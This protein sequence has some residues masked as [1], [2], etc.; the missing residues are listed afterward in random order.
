[1]TT[2]SAIVDHFPRGLLDPPE[3]P[4]CG[5][6]ERDPNAPACWHCARGHYADCQWI[7][8]VAERL[9][10]LSAEE[11][12]VWERLTHLFPDDEILRRLGTLRN[13]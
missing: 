4:V 10:S 1:L 2:V 12:R 7:R 5:G 3:C 6:T 9:P 8:D 13:R 11:K